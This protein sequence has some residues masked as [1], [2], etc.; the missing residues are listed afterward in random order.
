MRPPLA[1]IDATRD[2]DQHFVGRYEATAARSAV[3][4]V[5]SRE[6]APTMHVFQTKV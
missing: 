6:V 4:A 1:G 3:T 2:F 5:D